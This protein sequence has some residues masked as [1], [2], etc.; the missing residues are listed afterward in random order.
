VGFQNEGQVYR[1]KTEVLQGEFIR[2][3]AMQQL[4]LRF[5]RALL[6]QISQMAVCNRRHS[7]DQQVCRWLLMSLDRLA[8]DELTMTHE[9][10][11]NM[12]GVR[13]EGIS[14]AAHK[15]QSAGFIAYRRG[16]MTVLDRIGLEAC[17]CEC[18]RVMRREYD[19]LPH[20]YVYAIDPTPL[21]PGADHSCTGPSQLEIA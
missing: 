12:L 2:G 16:R 10:L 14:E 17:C 19:R 8:A 20:P 18:Y 1:L 9:M 11:A 21:E 6:T 7:I 3:G 5:T 13:R 4:L 15:L